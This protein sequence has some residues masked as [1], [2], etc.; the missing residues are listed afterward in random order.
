[1]ARKQPNPES[2]LPLKE[3]ELMVLL[4][5]AEQP[6]HGYVLMTRVQERSNGY[7][8]P[9]PASLYRTLGNLVDAGL[10]EEAPVPADATTD[11]V[12]RRYFQPSAFGHAVLQAE[13]RRLAALLGEA[14]AAGLRFEVGRP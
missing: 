8:A 11:D 14:R 1:M 3:L 12:R 10:L 13:L 5:T 9:G 7:V 6:L 2:L 4:A